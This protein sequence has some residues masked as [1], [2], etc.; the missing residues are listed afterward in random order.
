MR[1]VQLLQLHEQMSTMASL[2]SVPK[3]DGEE[4]SLGR[5][6]TGKA[7]AIG[8]T[9]WRD[10]F[11]VAREVAIAIP[12][13]GKPE[14]IAKPDGSIG[15]LWGTDERWLQVHINASL[16][17]ERIRWTVRRDGVDAHHTAP[18]LRPLVESLRATFPLVTQ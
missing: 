13:L 8:L 16:A 10:A 15:L 17:G 6:Q 4:D 1:A 12:H 18:T 14:P 3:W 9:Q 11:R 7:P 2:T 5:S